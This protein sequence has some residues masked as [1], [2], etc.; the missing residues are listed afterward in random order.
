MVPLED[1]GAGEACELSHVRA[2]VCRRF[3][4]GAVQPPVLIVID[5]APPDLDRVRVAES[6]ESTPEHGV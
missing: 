4:Q 1:H 3:N 6:E 5:S 2:D